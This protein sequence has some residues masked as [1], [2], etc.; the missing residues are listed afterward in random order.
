MKQKE[1]QAT[2]STYLPV[3]DVPSDKVGPWHCL[4]LPSSCLWW[5]TLDLLER[6]FSTHTGERKHTKESLG[7]FDMYSRIAVKPTS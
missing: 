6:V 3:H 2:D 4:H 5:S 7:K 1:E